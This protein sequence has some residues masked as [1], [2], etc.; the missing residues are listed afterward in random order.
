ML[1]CLSLDV[2]IFN[3][4]GIRNTHK[5]SFSKDH[6]TGA[7]DQEL[8]VLVPCVEITCLSQPTLGLMTKPRACKGAGQERSPRV[9]SHVPGS[10]GECEGMNLH[11]PK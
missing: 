5:I 1:L 7:V 8:C 6:K 4:L 11:T 10:V 2:K 9:T 3:Y